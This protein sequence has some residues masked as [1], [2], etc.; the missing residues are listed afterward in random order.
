[1]SQ[2]IRCRPL[3]LPEGTAAPSVTEMTTEIT[4]PI[5]AFR[6]A[7]RL[8]S[9]L[10]RIAGTSTPTTW[11]FKPAA[12]AIN[13]SHHQQLCANEVNS[14]VGNVTP[15]SISLTDGNIHTVTIQY[16]PPGTP[17]NT[18]VTSDASNLCIYLDQ[19][20]TPVLA[21]TTDLG[22][23]GLGTGGTAFVGFTGATGGD[24][25]TQNILSWSFSQTI[26]GTPLQPGTTQTFNFSTTPGAVDVFAAITPQSNTL[27]NSGAIPTVTSF[28]VPPATAAC[29]VG[30]HTAGDRNVLGTGLGKWK[31][32]S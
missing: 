6:T 23:I 15:L 22:N 16:N 25:E 12:L 7:W 17:C 3:D 13:T 26:V 4:T 27:Q 8:S 21:V 5:Q 20:T 24:F 2:L 31:L 29:V 9:I 14:T 30:W 28:S 10:T 19:T 1:M 18:A 32:R 11:Q